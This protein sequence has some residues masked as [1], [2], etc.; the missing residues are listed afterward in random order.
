MANEWIH[1][2]AVLHDFSLIWCC[3]A[4]CLVLKYERLGYSAGFM[5]IIC[6]LQV[7][8]CMHV[9]GLRSGSINCSSP[10]R[11]RQPIPFYLQVFPKKRRRP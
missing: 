8:L 11:Y 7:L 10:L 3:V 6:G 9:C 5:V 2:S 4:I 1:M